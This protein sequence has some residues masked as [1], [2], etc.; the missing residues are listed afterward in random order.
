MFTQDALYTLMNEFGDK[1]YLFHSEGDFRFQ[2]AMGIH[3]LYGNDRA[4]ICE[5]PTTILGAEA[6]IDITLWTPEGI[7]PIELK[8]QKKNNSSST[9][10]KNARNAFYK[11]V[12]RIEYLL[13]QQNKFGPVG[14]TIFLTEDSD[15]WTNVPGGDASAFDMREGSVISG[16]PI[17]GKEKPHATMWSAPSPFQDSYRIAW[18]DYNKDASLLNGVSRYIVVEVSKATLATASARSSGTLAHASR[19]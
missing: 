11:D 19:K 4:V 16:Q 14:Y 13:Y 12:W 15:Y 3:E 18:R 9:T 2:L 10:R 17:W 1:G 5:Y 7:L 6:R 8:H